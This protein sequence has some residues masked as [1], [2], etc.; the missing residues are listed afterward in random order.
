[1]VLSWTRERNE[2]G[3]GR[4]CDQHSG[5][6][7]WL[8]IGFP[9][10]TKTTSVQAL[11]LSCLFARPIAIKRD[12]ATP[13]KRTNASHRTR[14]MTIRRTI[15]DVQLRETGESGRTGETG[16]NRLCASR[17]SRASRLSRVP[18]N[19]PAEMKEAG[20]KKGERHGTY[21]ITRRIFREPAIR[22]APVQALDLQRTGQAPH[23]R[24]SR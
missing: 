8:P 14:H 16:G 21:R 3:M 24:R 19:T 17:E 23:P 9:G 1:M 2:E 18:A 4:R 22:L 11:S 5:V 13:G 7:H 12:H 15:A 10:R 20:G 6:S